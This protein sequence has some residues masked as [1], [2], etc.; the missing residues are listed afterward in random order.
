MADIV[1]FRFSNQTRD[2]TILI[3]IQKLSMYVY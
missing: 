2:I 1:Y 3:Y